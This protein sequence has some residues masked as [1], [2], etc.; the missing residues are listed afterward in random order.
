MVGGGPAGTRM[1]CGEQAGEFVGGGGADKAGAVIL[2]LS[3]FLFMNTV[4]EERLMRAE[5]V[6]QQEHYR[7][8]L[9]QQVSY[10]RR[11]RDELPAPVAKPESYEQRYFRQQQLRSELGNEQRKYLPPIRQ[12][13]AGSYG[14]Y[15]GNERMHSFRR[16]E[17]DRT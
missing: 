8:L 16:Q 14:S 3:I 2:R 10:N 13:E 5:R 17:E 12:E 11:S 4:A 7:K 6:R 1:D 15:G 9:D